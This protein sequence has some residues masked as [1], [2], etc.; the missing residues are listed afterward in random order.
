MK[1]FVT[2]AFASNVE[3]VVIVEDTAASP[4]GIL[5]QLVALVLFV[6]AIAGGD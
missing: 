3:P 2:A 5:V 4:Q 6:T 1:T